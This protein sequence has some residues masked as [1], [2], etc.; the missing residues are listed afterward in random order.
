M[1]SGNSKRFETENVKEMQVS[2]KRKKFDGE[3]AAESQC[4]RTPQSCELIQTGA[5]TPVP[6]QASTTGRLTSFRLAGNYETLD[7]DCT[8]HLHV[9]V[10]VVKRL[11]G[12]LALIDVHAEQ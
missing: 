10:E 5:V 6:L 11:R 7:V 9:R 1:W 2:H 12:N 3:L 8:K 4:F